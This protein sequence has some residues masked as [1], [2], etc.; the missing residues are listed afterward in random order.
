MLRSVVVCVF[1]VAIAMVLG[2][3]SELIAQDPEHV[4]PKHV[5]RHA[6]VFTGIP[7]DV[8]GQL[9]AANLIAYTEEQARIEY[10]RIENERLAAEEAARL[11][12]ERVARA[13]TAPVQPVV[14]PGTG[15]TGGD[16]SA[17]AALIGQAIVNRESG[18][19]PNAVNS[20]T[21][22]FGCAQVMPAWWSGRCAGL[23]RYSIAGQV[24]CV[25]I[26]L[27]T[28]GMSAWG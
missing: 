24:A 25:Q 2:L 17:V 26:I 27:S 3:V 5:V 12:A 4:R 14:S 9:D 21:G 28:Q 16:C 18:G 6:A 23:D 10:I 22:A 7:A 1:V 8:S 19:N 13:R 15:S 11:E 20:S